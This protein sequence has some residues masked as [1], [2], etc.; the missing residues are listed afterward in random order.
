M[1]SSVKKL[2][3]KHSGNQKHD[4]RNRDRSAEGERS[5]LM[6]LFQPF[7]FIPLS[8]L[9]ALIRRV[10]KSLVASYPCLDFLFKACFRNY[11]QAPRS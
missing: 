9:A 11:I 8:G 3:E 7:D 5:W 1:A 6:A 4:S 2:G 10:Y